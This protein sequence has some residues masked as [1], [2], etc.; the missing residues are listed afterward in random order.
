MKMISFVVPVL[1]EEGNVDLAYQA[2]IDI[3]ESRL[4]RF[5]F[6]IIFTDNHSTDKT[7]ENLTRLA[8]QDHRV[9]AIR[10]SRNVGY[11][12]SIHTGYSA[13]LGDAVIQ[14]DCDLQDPPGVIPTF[15]EKWEEGYKVVY[16]VRKSRCEFFATSLVRKLFY[17]LITRI[18]D[19]P[20]PHDAGDFR[21]VD[22]KLVNVLKTTNETRPYIRGAISAMGFDQIG[23]PYDRDSRKKGQSK[24]PLRAMV[25]LAI[26]GILSQSIVPLRI[27]VWLGLLV[28]IIT[29]LTAIG[30]L[31]GKLALGQDWP[32]GFAT[33]TFLLLTAI[34]LNAVFL[35]IIGEYL[36]RIFLQLR[37]RPFVIVESELNK[38][39]AAVVNE[40]EE[41]H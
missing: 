2:I 40:A 7:F 38:P 34:T 3:M 12:R 32:P 14:L 39:S 41:S 16:G 8:K 10:F 13:S 24:F 30:Y 6:E 21:L 11:Q 22:R 35:G 9:R 25:G 28:S 33:T 1:N 17:R 29:T 15:V 36:G 23:V 5:W 27:A 37:G 18:S 20:L 31:I 4:K 19:E 26:D